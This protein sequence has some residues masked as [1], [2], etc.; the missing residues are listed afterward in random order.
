VNSLFLSFSASIPTF[1]PQFLADYQRFSNRQTL[2]FDIGISMCD[3]NFTGLHSV[4]KEAIARHEPTVAFPLSNGVGR[5]LFLIFIPTD[6]TSGP[7]SILS[8]VS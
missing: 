2:L 4:F 6:Q 1:Y 3:F 5:F 7:D 8:D